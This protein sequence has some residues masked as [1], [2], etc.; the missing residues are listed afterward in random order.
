MLGFVMSRCDSV[1]AA[2][3]ASISGTVS[4]SCRAEYNFDCRVCSAN[5]RT[6]SNSAHKHINFADELDAFG[7]RYTVSGMEPE[8]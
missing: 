5:C 6:L 1:R 8:T 7:I 4:S 2:V 3:A